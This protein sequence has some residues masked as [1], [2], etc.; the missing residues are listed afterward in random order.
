[1]STKR[2]SQVN[3]KGRGFWADGEDGRTRD[4]EDN[5]HHGLKDQN[6]YYTLASACMRS[7]PWMDGR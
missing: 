5:R 7:E 3:N 6:S 4:V 1:M 2:K